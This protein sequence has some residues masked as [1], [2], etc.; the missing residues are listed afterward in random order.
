MEELEQK[1]V[2]QQLTKEAENRTNEISDFIEEWDRRTNKALEMDK[3]GTLTI[4]HLNELFEFVSSKLEKYK[5]VEN[6]REQ[7]YSRY[8][9]QLTEEQF[10]VWERFRFALNSVH[11]C[12]K[13]FNSF[14]ER[15]SDYKPSNVDSIRNQVREILK[16][17]GYIVDSYFESDYVTW[18]GVYARPENKPTYLDPATSEDAYLQNKYRVDDFKQDFAE[19]FEWEIANDIVQP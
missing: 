11:I 5:R 10:A 16:K 7:C 6:R 3:E 19:W 1:K 12:R 17:K 14:V 15:F 18:V 2:I 8:R 13:N 4:P 9:D